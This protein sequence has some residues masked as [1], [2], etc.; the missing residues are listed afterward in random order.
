M[1]NKRWDIFCRVIDNYGDAGVCWRLARQLADEFDLTVRL[2]IDDLTALQKLHPPIDLSQA[3]QISVNVAIFLWST[4]LPQPLLAAD[5]VIEAFAC[6][7]PDEYRAAMRERHSQWINLE[8]L[9]AEDWVSGCHG[10]PSPQSG[11]SLA[12]SSLERAALKKYFFFPGFRNDTGGVLGERDLPQ[13]R[14]AFQSQENHRV[15]FF[16]R[17]GVAVSTDAL[18]ISLFAY[19]YAPLESLLQV[20]STQSPPIVCLVPEGQPLAAVSQFFGEELAVGSV[21]VRGPLTIVVLP[22]LTQDDYDRLLW[23]CDVNFVRGEDSFVRAQWAARPFVWQI[24]AQEEGAHWP[25]LDAFTALYSEQMGPS[26]VV[27]MSDFWHAWN[28]DGSIE[29]W[30]SYVEALPQLHIGAERWAEQL[31]AGT[32]LAAALVQFCANQV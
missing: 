5:V 13:R 30:S 17:F 3:Q 19:R 32:N 7:I 26:A 24:Y 15:E 29:S 21:R 6:E 8:Y 22:F 1:T 27:A 18:V 14:R 10:L 20:W 4:P 23:S 31:E 9:S 28:G 2:W 16:R 25:K 12:G 11:S